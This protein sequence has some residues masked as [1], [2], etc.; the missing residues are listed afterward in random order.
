MIARRPGK[1][2]A[3]AGAL[4]LALLAMRAP[5]ARADDLIVFEAASLKDAFAAVATK[6]QAAHPGTKVVPN[7]AG[8]QELRAQI[9]HGAPADVFASADW[10][11]MDALTAA[12]LV[13]APAVLTCNQ[14]VVVT[15]PGLDTVKGL[16]DLPRAQRVVVGAAEV[17]VG[18]YTNK[19]LDDAAHAYGAD[20]R[21][22][23]DLSVV[24]RELN[25]KQVLA[26]VLIGEADA[27][28]VYASDAV[29]AKGKVRVLPLPAGLSPIAEYPIAVLR[30][31]HHPEL[32]H[33]FVDLL[34]GPVGTAALK[35][36]GFTPCPGK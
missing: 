12:R 36:A 34:K 25:V 21:K 7:A 26:K 27:A 5:A 17:P 20:F 11:Q 29:A 30:G 9:Q 23:V 8:S 13:E 10:R 16:G 6:F 2:R 32:A 14:L 19:M 33:A 22:R 3:A 28:V 18:A 31:T 35:D 24:S 4:M 1:R 15:R